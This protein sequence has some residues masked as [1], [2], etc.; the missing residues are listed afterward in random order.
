[1]KNNRPVVILVLVVL[2][3]VAFFVRWEEWEYKDL[4][5]GSVFQYRG[6]LLPWQEAQAPPAGTN[7][8]AV[9]V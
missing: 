4:N 5:G 9:A 7:V 8:A 1:M 2:A 3:L 6:A